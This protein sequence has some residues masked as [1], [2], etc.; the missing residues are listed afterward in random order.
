MGYFGGTVLF[1]SHFL[2]YNSSMSYRP[3]NSADT[4]R[5]EELANSLTHGFGTLLAISGLVVLTLF[6]QRSG[7]GWQLL[8][9]LIFGVTLILLYAAST[10]YHAV[11]Q[12][13]IKARL[14]I[15]DHSAILLLI[16]GTYT[17]FTLVSLRGPWGWSLF[18]VVWGLA[19]LGI[20][21]E[22][23]RLRRF[24][25][26]LITLYVVMGWAAVAAIKPLLAAVEGGG[27]QLMLAGGI[28]YTSGI[29]FYLWRSLPY[30]HAIWHLFVLAGSCLHF[31]AV[32]L[33]VLPA[34]SAGN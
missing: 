28:A 22:A 8:S 27:L 17:P 19:L 2:R 1:N 11:R 23:T 15:L 25:A 24:R 10:L 4:S 9:C 29:L 6:A 33:Y 20:F 31:F 13:E 12:P 16:A 26:A 21:V 5:S 14:R 7:D 34:V 32:L 30:H 18:A 3:G